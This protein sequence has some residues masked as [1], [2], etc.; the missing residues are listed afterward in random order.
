[1]W[2]LCG[3][4]PTITDLV[5]YADFCGAPLPGGEDETLPEAWEITPEALGKLLKSENPPL[6]VDVRQPMEQQIAQIPG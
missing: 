2:S 5:D 3:E 1:R 6:L 4:T